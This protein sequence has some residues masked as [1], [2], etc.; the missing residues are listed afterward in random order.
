MSS[1][2]FFTPK[3]YQIQSGPIARTYDLSYYGYDLYFKCQQVNPN[4][5]TNIDN[6]ATGTT[7]GF[8]NTTNLPMRA[9]QN[10]LLSNKASMVLAGPTAKTDLNVK[11]EVTPDM[12][13][14]VHEVNI[15]VA[16]GL[17]IDTYDTGNPVLSAVSL[18]SSYEDTGEIIPQLTNAF[19]T[20]FSALSA[21]GTQIFIVNATINPYQL[22]LQKARSL[23]LNFKTVSNFGTGNT[24]GHAGLFQDFSYGKQLATPAP[25]YYYP[26]DIF[27][28]IHPTTSHVNPQYISGQYTP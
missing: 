12:D 27:F 22:V 25:I 19:T 16:F 1:N 14:L 8:V 23:L 4:T 15:N 6:S 3:D 13:A 24:T 28:H 11:F 2:G 20:G 17:N 10:V 5:L 18:T 9:N 21:A 7:F 26:S